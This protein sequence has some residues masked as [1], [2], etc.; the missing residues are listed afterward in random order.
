[1]AKARARAPHR[2]L[3]AA[4]L[5]LGVVLV[6]GVVV[7]LAAHNFAKVSPEVESRPR[8]AD[9]RKNDGLAESEEFDITQ[10]IESRRI[11]RIK[12]DSVRQVSEEFAHLTDVRV[13]LY[14]EDG[15]TVLVTS[16]SA[17]YNLETQDAELR[18]HVSLRG[19]SLELDTRSL[20]L[21]QV[22]QVL[23]SDG[24]VALRYPPDLEGRASSLRVDL[25]KDRYSMSGGVHLRSTPGA[26]VRFKLDCDKLNH[27]R[28]EGMI[29][30][31]GEVRLERNNDWIESENLTLHFSNGMDQLENA[32]AR[33]DVRGTF[34]VDDSRG[35]LRHR[36]GVKG[37]VLV[38]Q[39]EPIGGT[40]KRVQ[41]EAGEGQRAELKVIDDTGFGQVFVGKTLA[42]YLEGGIMRLIEGSGDGLELREIV[43][44]PQ[45]VVLRQAC[46]DR[47]E[48]RFDPQGAVDRVQLD[49]QVE[50]Q[51]GEVYLAGGQ[52]ANLDWSR[53][54][55]DISGK[56]V[57]LYSRRGELS[58]PKFVFLRDRGLIRAEDGVYAQ[59]DEEAAGALATTPLARGEGPVHIQADKANWTL[60]PSSFTFI[61]SVRAWR[62][63]NLLT[64]N[65]LRGQEANQQ[66]SASGG[67]VKTVFEPAGSFDSERPGAPVEVVARQ[68]TYQHERDRLVYIGGVRA[69]QGQRRMRCAE[70]EIE[71]SPNEGGV[72]RM[73]CSDDVEI[74]DTDTGRRILG[75]LAV[76]HLEA[77]T[78]EVF[79]ERIKVREGNGNEF[80]CGY[81]LYDVDASTVDVR[82]TAPADRAAANAW[83]GKPPKVANEASP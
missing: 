81:L 42:G 14:R 40:P 24:Q 74:E 29:R 52:R 54:R 65:Q 23:V 10:T 69:L 39:F 61:G 2:L 19:N 58:S 44:A 8:S 33:I 16:D 31:V 68:L 15:E 66:L 36:V 76:Y 9:T 59:L 56:N 34:D 20:K 27:E 45:P 55:V 26:P 3:R 18:G 63:P 70:L 79:G 1:M 72:E 12:A 73:R 43:D 60:D 35:W 62:G 53:N 57:T 4:L 37:K 28:D 78:I 75:D 7:L 46:A 49:G 6:L 50:L 21:S 82:S 11:F 22:G 41:L 13:E 38:V 5:L 80:A 32:R 51:D 67:P 83:I 25:T 77:S 64:A 30:A 71:L 48:A 17:D 47:F